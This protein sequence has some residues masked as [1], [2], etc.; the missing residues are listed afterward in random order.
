MSCNKEWKQCVYCEESLKGKESIWNSKLHGW[1]CEDC[2]D[3]IEGGK[4][5]A[6]EEECE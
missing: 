4:E 6:F 5:S 3:P 1:V 2:T